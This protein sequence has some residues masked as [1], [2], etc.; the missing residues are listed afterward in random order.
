MESLDEV[1]GQGFK[2]KTP[3]YGDLPEN[4]FELLSLDE[5]AFFQEEM[6]Q[7]DGVNVDWQLTK[8]KAAITAKL[9]DDTAEEIWSSTWNQEEMQAVGG[10]SPLSED[11]SVSS[12]EN[13]E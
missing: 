3:Q 7:E 5:L 1:T 13:E 11:S 6:T 10:G 12:E 2:Y 9:G 4:G 8:I